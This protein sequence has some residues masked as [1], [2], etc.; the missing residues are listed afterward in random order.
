[1]NSRKQLELKIKSIKAHDDIETQHQQEILKWLDSGVEIY[2]R[3]KPE[4]E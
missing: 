3:Q 1:M 4:F 2:R